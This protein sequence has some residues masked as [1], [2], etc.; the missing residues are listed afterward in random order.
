MTEAEVSLRIALYYINNG[1]TN[2]NVVVSID[3]AQVRTG[4]TIHFDISEFLSRIGAVKKV[5][6]PDKW[7]GTYGLPKTKH[8][9]LI[10]STP[11]IGDV[12]IQLKEGRTLYIESKKGA[13]QP[14]TNGQ[15]YRLMHEAIGQLITRTEHHDEPILA[16]AIPYNAKTN[17]L[18]V[19]WIECPQIKAIGIKF[20]LVHED[21]D[22]SHI[23]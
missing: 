20:L 5:G 16:I 12:I 6:S 14:T 23:S 21:G 10:C 9:L 3:G 1:L 17:E 2:S 19:R 13:S 8:D 7:Q 22:I 4:N 15:E 11:G 18:A